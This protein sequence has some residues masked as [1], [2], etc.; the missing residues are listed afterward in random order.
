MQ[1]INYPELFKNF[2]GREDDL[3]RV[4]RYYIYTPMF[5]RSN[6]FTHS[7]R[8]LWLLQA[9]LPLAEEIFGSRFDSTKAQLLAVVHDDPE[10]IMGDIQAGHKRKMNTEQLAEVQR[11]ERSAIA[12]MV[13][14]YPYSILGYRYGD[15]MTEGQ[16][17]KTLEAKLLKYIDRFDAFGEALH[18]IHAGNRAFITNSIHPEFGVIDTPVAFYQMYLPSFAKNNSE[19]AE[20]FTLHH[21]LFNIEIFSAAENVV[22]GGRPHTKKTILEKGVYQPYET[23]KAIILANNDEEEMKNLFVQKEF[24]TAL[25]WP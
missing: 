6:L 2:V 18:E 11:L 4:T 9:I 7:K 17:L 25:G 1:K 5:Y 12:A 8:V 21:P 20:L 10:I 24:S 13:E 19:F 14:R 15:L 16:E 22:L 23:W 3:R